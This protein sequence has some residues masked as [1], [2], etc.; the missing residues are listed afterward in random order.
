LKCHSLKSVTILAMT[1]F[2]ECPVGRYGDECN[3]LCHC[4]DEEP[5]DRDTGIC[6][7]P[8]YDVGWREKT[9]N[10]SKII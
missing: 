10:L 4:A 9:C 5:C 2:S 7:M 3:E 6:S 1:Q 8:V